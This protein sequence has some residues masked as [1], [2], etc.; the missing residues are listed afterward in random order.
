[1]SQSSVVTTSGN[2]ATAAARRSTR[3]EKSVPLIILG[4]NRVGEPFME[5]TVALSLNKHGCRYASRHDYGVGTW[6]TLQIV[7]LITSDEK[8]ATVR[9]MVR[10][11]HPPASSRELQQVGVEL[12]TPSNVWGIVQPPMDWSTTE[13]KIASAKV[14]TLIS[15]VEESPAKQADAREL[16]IKPESRLSPTSSP[17]RAEVANFPAPSAVVSGSTATAQDNAHPHRVVVTADGLIS[18]I[19][20]RL[21]HEVEKAVETAV[22]KKIG[23]V[24]REALSSVENARRTSV[25]EIQE[26]FPK[27][28]EAMR[29][30]LNDNCLELPAQWKAD[31]ETHRSRSEEMAQRLE[32]QAAELRLDLAN[33]REY[34]EKVT[35]EVPAQIP[36]RLNEALTQ[37]TSDFEA[38]AAL[39]IDRRYERLRENVQ[40]LTQEALLKLNARSAEVQ[41]MVQTAVNSGLQEL[42]RE[43]EVHV[44]TILAETKQ[45]VDA[46]LSSLD[47]ESRAAFEARLRVLNAEMARSADCATQE[48]QE[49]MKAFLYSCLVAAVG[50]VDEHAK[51]TLD[52][53][54]RNDKGVVETSHKLSA[55]ES[56]S[57]T[58]ANGQRP[59]T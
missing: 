5:R 26:L 27:R 28:I 21:Q 17:K 43:T 10:S 37:A 35:R 29:L 50:A 46:T 38:A 58:D 59:T 36:V 14:A 52:D 31:M 16:R 3:I 41:A 53:L 30:S 44:N 9:A 11:V 20:G 40:V 49:G 34:M 56:Q 18:A 51:T 7:G 22:E 4:Q 47:A 57:G 25:R 8:P 13:T 55:N 23:D 12:E 2:G 42:Q 24:L 19:H 32:R 39:M 45:R 54:L 1:M 33:A 15:P 48:F 6:V